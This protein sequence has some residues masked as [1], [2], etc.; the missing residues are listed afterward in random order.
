LT[1]IPRASCY[2]AILASIL[3]LPLPH[4]L[5]L[6]HYPFSSLLNLGGK[7]VQST[8]QKLVVQQSQYL[9]S[10]KLQ[11]GVH[12]NQ[13]EVLHLPIIIWSKICHIHIAPWILARYSNYLLLDI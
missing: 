11:S 8:L 10:A 9:G 1:S 5:P 13:E 3:A 12:P 7:K 2:T 6:K 4:S